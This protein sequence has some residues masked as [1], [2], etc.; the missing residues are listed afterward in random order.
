MTDNRKPIIRARDV[1][2]PNIHFIE[3]I[4]T[5]AEAAEMMREKK[6]SCLIVQ[7]R[8]ADDAWG[9]VVVRDI[10]QAMVIGETQPGSVNVYEIMSKPIVTVPSDMDIRYVARLMTKLEI[11]RLPVEDRGELV[12]LV[13]QDDL[14]MKCK[15]V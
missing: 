1:M 3:G 12:G 8:T 15:L 5:A 14:V 6:T 13:T 9:L 10:I 11:R 7:K 2:D 4:A